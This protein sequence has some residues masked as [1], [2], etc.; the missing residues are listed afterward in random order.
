[1]EIIINT[2]FKNE[3]QYKE[4]I[5]NIRKRRKISY[6]KSSNLISRESNKRK[7]KRG[8]DSGNGH[9]KRETSSGV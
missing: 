3:I 5:S 9:R 4:I 2:I 6:F 1:M 7:D 8:N